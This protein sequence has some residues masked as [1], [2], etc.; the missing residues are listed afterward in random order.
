[1]NEKQLNCI[2][3]NF[4]GKGG[5]GIIVKC[6]DKYNKTYVIKLSDPSILGECPLTK[7]I[8]NAKN[9]NNKMFY[10]PIVFNTKFGKEN[11]IKYYNSSVIGLKGENVQNIYTYEM[12]LIQNDINNAKTEADKQEAIMRQEVAL[13]DIIN[14]I[15]QAMTIQF[16]K[17]NNEHRKCL[18]V[19][20]YCNKG[21]LYEF[22]KNHQ[23]YIKDIEL[24]KDIVYQIFCGL[25]YLY[26]KK[27]CHWDLK[28]ENILVKTNTN[29]IT[30]KINA[31]K[32]YL[33]KI[34]DYGTVLLDPKKTII[35]RLVRFGANLMDKSTALKFMKDNMPKINTQSAVNN[36]DNI[37]PIN[38][39]INQQ[40]KTFNTGEPKDISYEFQT[41]QAYIPPNPFE[42]ATFYRDI[43]AFV[44]SIFKLLHP[45]SELFKKD[46]GPT[47]NNAK[48]FK[49][50]VLASKKKANNFI[51]QYYKE[52]PWSKKAKLLW[53]LARIVK[54]IE[55]K[56]EIQSEYLYYIKKPNGLTYYQPQKYIID[57]PDKLFIELYNRISE[58]FVSHNNKTIKNRALRTITGRHT[59][60]T[61]KTT[62]NLLSH[63][64]SS[65]DSDTGNYKIPENFGEDLNENGNYF[66]YFINSSK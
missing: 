2:N 65:N 55:E 40:E 46:D 25:V 36:P 43:Y 1:M 12:E 28:P 48:K 44:L 30:G 45:N 42:L 26:N 47:T 7:E 59:N 62:P 13:N 37:D 64:I 16:T 63:V 23:E 53:D 14:Q 11:I 15:N 54:D 10:G 38:L 41:T 39:F 60:I 29:T 33:F 8:E 61:R 58:L 51:Y 4:L 32:K 24:F 34:A 56:I 66:V 27:I 31:K 52:K 6:K 57:V 17:P 18:A 21:D 49:M 35:E 19:L 22:I 20:E 50:S 9:I 3:T 5:E